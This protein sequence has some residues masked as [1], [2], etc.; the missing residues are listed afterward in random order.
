MCSSCQKITPAVCNHFLPVRTPPPIPHPRSLKSSTNVSSKG[1]AEHLKALSQ[2]ALL[3]SYMCRSL[4]TCLGSRIPPG[5]KSY[6][7]AATDLSLWRLHDRC[8]F[9]PATPPRTRTP[10]PLRQCG[11]MWSFGSGLSVPEPLQ[12]CERHVQTLAASWTSC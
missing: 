9:G 3:C 5:V 1:L 2:H 8:F 10:H 12:V 7:L 4:A 11:G 6:F